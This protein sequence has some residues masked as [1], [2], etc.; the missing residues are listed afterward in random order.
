[1]HASRR[2]GAARSGSRW[3][4]LAALLASVPAQAGV[5]NDLASG[6][7]HYLTPGDA[8]CVTST[9]LDPDEVDEAPI[10]CPIRAYANCLPGGEADLSV[11]SCVTLRAVRGGA[12]AH[13]QYWFRVTP[14]T[15]GDDAA[16]ATPSFVPIHI[17]APQVVWD[18]KLSNGALARDA[19]AVSATYIL[20]LRSEPQDDLFSRGGV[21]SET[22][23]LLASHGGVNGCL[24]VPTGLGDAA[25]LALA[26]V[27]ASDQIDQ[28]KASPSIAAV[29]E[30]GRTYSIEI[31]MDLLADKRATAQPIGPYV[32]PRN[33]ISD[34]PGPLGTVLQW[35]QLVVTVGSATDDL[36]AQ[37]DELRAEVDGLREDLD[38]HSHPYLT[39]RGTGHNNVSATTGLPDFPDGDTS[40]SGPGADADADGVIDLVDVCPDSPR[41]LP[42]DLAGCTAA[43]FC[44]ERA[45]RSSCQMADWRDDEGRNPRDCRW[46]NRTCAATR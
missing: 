30:V 29:V 31:A 21:V 23:I 19:G 4:A 43:E 11:T 28:G 41:G 15:I 16:P 38:G 2:R 35:N 26:C 20:R 22:P 40:G 39:G 33:D 13:Y 6:G 3:L 12:H 46:R 9:F 32:G 5:V 36:Q 10:L 37:I 45:D 25:N 27:A 44:S 1:M 17:F 34:P 42:T 18:L 7:T 8:Q 24:S 14:A